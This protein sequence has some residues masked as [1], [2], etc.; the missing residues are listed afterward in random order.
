MACKNVL[1]FFFI[2]VLGHKVLKKKQLNYFRLLR[3]VLCEHTHTHTHI[4]WWRLTDGEGWHGANSHLK[5]DARCSIS[6]VQ[7]GGFRESH[8]MLRLPQRWAAESIR[9]EDARS[10]RGFV[11]LIFEN[12]TG[13][14]V[15]LEKGNL[16]H[17]EKEVDILSLCSPSWLC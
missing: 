4:R 8:Q 12:S 17:Q 5:S 9:S 1:L 11:A 7:R 2:T 14:L 10:L 15:K 6:P 3:N 16:W 13:H